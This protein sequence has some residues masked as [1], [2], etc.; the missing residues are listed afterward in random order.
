MINTLYL[1]DM[2]ENFLNL[3]RATAKNFQLT[4][5][6]TINKHFPLEIM[7]KMRMFALTTPLQN[8]NRG[9]M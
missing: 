4:S 2:E 8:C 1:Q 6:L 5:Y 9:L 3:K 7:N